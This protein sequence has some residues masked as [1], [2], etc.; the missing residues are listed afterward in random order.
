MHRAQAQIDGARREFPSVEV[1][2]VAQHNGAVER[3]A[4]FRTVP[5]HELVNGVPMT[6]LSIGRREAV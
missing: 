5:L 3:E 2:A 6:A 4:R 1:N